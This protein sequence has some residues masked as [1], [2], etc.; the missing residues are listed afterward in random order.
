VRAQDEVN[1][2]L[3][4]KQVSG[5]W[6][7]YRKYRPNEEGALP[8]TWWDDAKYSA[9]ES[10]TRILKDLFGDREIF[11]YPKS[12]FLVEDCLRAASCIPES[13]SM[14]FFAGSGTTAHAVINLNRE[15]G[16]RRKY[17]LVE[18]ADYFDTV[19]LPRIKKVIFC[20]KWQ[21][22]KA[23]GGNGVS[24]FVK[25]YQLEQ[26][27]DTLRR[28]KY[29]DSDL[30]DD[31]NQDPYN[32]YVFLRDLKLLEALQVDLKKNKVKVDL[33]KLYKGIDI[34]ETLS[35]LTGKWIKRITPDSVEFD[36]GDIIDIRNLDYRLI[37][38]LIWW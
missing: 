29:D 36:D 19:I 9:T 15:D 18:Q 6:Q 33:T 11:S 28:V 7:V 1:S 5:I 2:N 35:N 8:T 37:K 20:E 14:D 21:N 27:E 34:A 38:P 22:G 26:Y 23:A 31:P 12:V 25:Y 13:I 3:I 24:H 16:G 32:Q 10:G 17:I 30:F 4:G